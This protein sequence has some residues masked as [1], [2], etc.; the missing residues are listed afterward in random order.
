MLVTELMIPLLMVGFGMLFRKHPP[1]QINSIY[2]YRTKM[3]MKNQETWDYAHFYFGRQW[4]RAGLGLFPV[5]V[6]AMMLLYGKSESE[7]GIGAIILTV[8]QVTV[9]VL[10]IAWTERALHKKFD[11]DGKILDGKSKGNMEL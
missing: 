4:R 9:L 6:L 8:L 11:A 10:P 2:G 5:S 1:R 7:I 3:S